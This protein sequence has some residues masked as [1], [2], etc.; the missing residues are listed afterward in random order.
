MAYGILASWSRI[1]PMPPAW[2]HEVLTTGPP[3]KSQQ[4]YFQTCKV[5]IVFRI[6]F[7]YPYLLSLICVMKYSCPLQLMLFTDEVVIIM[8]QILT[9]SSEFNNFIM[10]IL[11]YLA[12]ALKK[13]RRR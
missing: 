13:W 5:Y 8:D 2:D 4:C 3:G 9:L 6:V 12:K 1:I 10:K 7:N 11:S